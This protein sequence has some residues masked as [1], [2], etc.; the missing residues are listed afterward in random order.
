M[1]ART[2][3]LAYGSLIDDPGR[4]IFDATIETIKDG[5]M[6]PFKVEFARKSRERANAP[7]L[8][9]VEKGGARVQAQ[10]FVLNV[11]EEEAANRLYRREINRVGEKNIVYSRPKNPGP[12]SVIIERLEAFQGLNIVLYTSIEANIEDPTP[13]KLAELAIE[14]ARELG[15]GRD[16][17][18]YLINAK[19][20]GIRTLLS[21][22]YEEEIKRLT[23]SKDLPEALENVRRRRNALI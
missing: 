22:A 13:Q 16:G 4:E 17:I 21:D 1:S 2:G 8:V 19:R 18:T 23:K 11:S 12:N 14:S 7:T 20:N 5:V 9:L 10:I 3:I 6:T 15:D